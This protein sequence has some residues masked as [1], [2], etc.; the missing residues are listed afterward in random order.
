M[1][2]NI[3][4]FQPNE[5]KQ[6]IIETSTGK[7]AR[8]PVKTPIIKDGDD[9]KALLGELVAPYLEEGDKIYIS[10]KIIAISQGRAFPL[11]DIKPSR[12]AK[13]LVRFV[14]KSP[15]GI[16]LGS[17]WTMELAV[18]EVGRFKIVCVAII[19][20]IAKIFGKRGVF[21]NILGPQVRAIDGPCDYTLPPYNHYAKLAPAKPHEVAKELTQLTGAQTI[22][23]DANDIG[24]NILGKPDKALNDEE[25][26]AIFG[27]NPLGQA[28]EQ[29]PIA[30]I[31]RIAE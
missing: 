30:I 31:R 14:Y 27:D 13:M 21:Y 17:P 4:A 3:E 15:Y 10:E 22:I 25:L 7:Y 20:G 29:T 2:A 8:Y 12:L 16:G 24:V 26:G 18:R 28:S 1:S 11:E 6:L 9:I 19:A 23:I 5:G